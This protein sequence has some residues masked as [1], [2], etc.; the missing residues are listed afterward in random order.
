[1]LRSIRWSWLAL[2]AGAYLAF[3]VAT[4]PAAT[5]YHWLAPEALR[6]SGITGTAWSGRATL[7]SAAGLAFRDARW[8]LRPGAL[9]LGRVEGNLE[10]RLADGFVSTHAIARPGRVVLEDVQASASL[11]TLRGVLPPLVGDATAQ[12]SLRLDRFVVDDGWPVNAV[13]TVRIGNLAVP[14]FAGLGGGSSLIEIGSFALEF[15]DTGGEGLMAT[16]MDTSGPLELSEASL[17]LGLERRYMLRGRAR[18]RDGA[19]RELVRG[20]EFLAPEA[21]AEGMREFEFDGSL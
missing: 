6:L 10:A 7:G 8:S 5:A 13:G 11:M 1:M 4:L 18:A 9:L 15:A 19:S 16:V 2:G 21:D 14:P 3:A 17:S 12:L 20:L